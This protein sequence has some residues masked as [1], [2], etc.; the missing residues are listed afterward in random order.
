[1]VE[2]P[3]KKMLAAGTIPGAEIATAATANEWRT[4][5]GCTSPSRLL[6]WAIG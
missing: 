6:A 3:D 1:M 4:E 5:V 2:L